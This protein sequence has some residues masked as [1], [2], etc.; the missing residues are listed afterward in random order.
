MKIH[1]R[2]LEE[3][4]LEMVMRWRLKP[5]VAKCMFTTI[6]DDRNKQLQWFKKISND[7]TVQYWIIMSGDLAIGVVNLASIDHVNRRCTAGYYIGELEYRNLGAIVPPFLY[8]HVFKNMGFQKIYGEVLSGNDTILKIHGLHG[9]RIVGVCK[10][11]YVINGQCH[12]AVLI[13]LLAEDWMLKKRYQS[14]IA[15]FETRKVAHVK[16]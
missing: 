2:P 9:Y 14:D 5:E 6:E 16:A 12:D 15:H 3:H 7:S 11:H 1:F 13:E 8:N 4:D 10:N